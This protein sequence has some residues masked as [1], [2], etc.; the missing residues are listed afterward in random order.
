MKTGVSLYSFHNYAKENSLGVKGCIKKAAE[1][2][3]DGLDF[4]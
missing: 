2:G 3:I 4:Y 1:M